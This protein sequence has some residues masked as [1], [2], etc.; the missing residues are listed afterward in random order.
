MTQPPAPAE[1]TGTSGGSSRP[2][3]PTV[4]EIP[5]KP[6]PHQYTEPDLSDALTRTT[7]RLPR[8]IRRNLWQVGV[9][10]LLAGIV[11]GGAGV[12]RLADIS[13]GTITHSVLLPNERRVIVQLDEGDQRAIYT[14]RGGSTTRCEVHGVQDAPIALDEPAPVL[15]QGADLLWRAEA[16]FTAPETGDYDI[17]C[18]DV[19][20]ARVGR[21]VGPFDLIATALVAAVGGIATLAGTALLVLWGFARRSARR[22]ARRTPPGVAPLA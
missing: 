18:R 15:L 10:M 1:H 9:G 12:T 8:W 21:P 22:R 14:S 17:T 2:R 19:V 13:E 5:R 11:V 20:Q 6:R 16:I 3:V 4:E 7:F